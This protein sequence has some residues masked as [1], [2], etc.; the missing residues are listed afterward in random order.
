MN[1]PEEN[2][3]LLNENGVL[4]LPAV[5]GKEELIKIKNQ[6]YACNNINFNDSLGALLISD[7]LW[8]EH[9]ALFSKTSLET[10]LHPNL[11]NLLDSYFGEEAILGSFKYQKKISGG[12]FISLHRDKGPG[13]VIFIYL[14][15][16]SIKTG[17]TRFIKGSH[18]LLINDI[19]ESKF[20]D[21]EYVDKDKY[22][23]DSHSIQSIGEK[24]GTIQIFSQ[25]ILHDLPLYEKAGREII[26]AIF[27]PK[28][29]AILCEDH[30]FRNNN[31][32]DLTADQKSRLILNCKSE[33]L[34]FTKVGKN[35][36]TSDLYK[37]SFLRKIYYIFRYYLFLFIDYM[38]STFKIK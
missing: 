34:S 23:T 27:Y 5:L 2:L 33:G 4:I 32:L 16:I 8:I 35:R 31:L 10:I 24:A 37:I 3:N 17:A 9:L 13:L 25:N 29:A 14:N 7:N 36:T 18:K 12:K 15:D 11:L 28:S 19:N 30:L 26:F 38:L 20:N 6:I 1:I 22:F 21:A